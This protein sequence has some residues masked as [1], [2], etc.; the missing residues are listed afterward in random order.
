[1]N[2]TKIL[3]LCFSLLYNLDIKATSPDSLS[4]LYTFRT[5]EGSVSYYCSNINDTTIGGHQYLIMRNQIVTI[6]G[7][8]PNPWFSGYDD[9]YI[10]YDST[11]DICYRS[12]GG[13]ET[14]IYNYNLNLG[15]TLSTSFVLSNIDSI[16]LLDQS[17]RKRLIFTDQWFDTIVWVKG[18]GNLEKPFKNTSLYFRTEGVL[19]HHESWTH[20]YENPY[21]IVPIQ[22]SNFNVIQESSEELNISLFPVPATDK[23]Y[24]T[25]PKRI[26]CINI[27]SIDGSKK[28]GIF[29][30]MESVL[31]LTNCQPGIIFL[32]IIF[33]DRMKFYKRIL[34]AG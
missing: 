21:N 5:F 9:F 14:I 20:L 2:K 12:N 33:E 13:P 11:G 32:E 16:Q 3:V 34:K 24:F 18:I 29:S 28:S 30:Q 25:S 19:C 17:Y 8:F 31:D 27:I 23:I 26:N 15:D 1:M 7:L 4:W 22:C 10:R 6:P